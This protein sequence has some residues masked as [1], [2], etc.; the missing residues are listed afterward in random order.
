MSLFF[1]LVQ[2]SIVGKIVDKLAFNNISEN[3][4][5]LFTGDNG[6]WMVKGI[7]GGSTGLLYGRS[8]GYWNV[9]KGSTWEGGIHEAGFATWPGTIR[10]Q[11]KSDEIVSS[12]DLL[13]TASALAG[14][15]LPSHLT[16]DG[17]DMSK[18]LLDK[19]KSQHETLFFYG[20]GG[21]C[22]WRGPSAMRYGEYKAHFSTG[23]G[24]SGCK[25]CEHICYCKDPAN[26][27]C[28]ILLFNIREDPSEAYPVN[29]KTDVVN[30]VVAALQ[31]EM[32][33]FTY[34]KLVAPPDG[35]GEGPGK[36]GVCCDR[37]KGCDCSGP[38]LN[39]D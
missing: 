1:C 16:Y 22:N 4:L 3:T 34:G 28:D 20:G 23:P 17:R 26:N 33:T 7:S 25:N 35:P 21:G 12:M 9:G 30:A 6:P 27:N 14:V 39:K 32:A 13:P 2:D 37:E 10:S 38:L 5:I 18:I 24:L 19:G 29:N 31:H 11:T 8:S 15:S 36:Y